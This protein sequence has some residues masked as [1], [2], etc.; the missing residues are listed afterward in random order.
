MAFVSVE[1]ILFLILVCGI[2]FILPFKYRCGWLLLASY[3]FYILSS[4]KGTAFLLFSTLSV[5]GAGLLMG[6]ADRQARECAAAAEVPL[7]RAEKKEIKAESTSK[8]KRIMLLVLLVNLGILVFLKYYTFFADIADGVLSRSPLSFQMPVLRLFLPLGISFYTLQAIG[9]LVDVY[10]GTVK[11]DRNL[12]SFALFMS[13]FPQIVQGPIPRH[14]QLAKQLFTPHAFAYDRAAQGAQLILW[15]FM[16][17]LLIADRVAPLV[18]EIFSNYESYQGILLL[19]GPLGYGLEVYADFS[20]GM[21][22]AR[23]VAQILGIELSDNFRQ[24]YFSRSVDE[25]WRRWHMS[26]G[27]WMK[28]YVFFPI[29]LSKS[30]GKM[31]KAAR[32]RF[33]NEIGKLIPPFAATFLVFILVGV[34]HGSGWKYVAYGVWNGVF[35]S[36]GILLESW[37]AKTLKAC[38]INAESA[39][40]RIFQMIRTTFYITVGRFFSRGL[41]F[42]AA[43]HMIK[44][45][46]ASGAGL[47]AFSDGTVFQ[48]GINAAN[49]AV[50]GIFLVLLLLVDLFHEKGIPIRQTIAKQRL[51]IRWLIYLGALAVLLVFG[52]YGNGIESTVFIYQQF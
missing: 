49:M 32:K 11:P 1:F 46:F 43:L 22:I 27:S 29:S 10:R 34:W 7:T 20:A 12:A 17:K 5:W 44:N 25:F 24:P 36:A 19:L 15:G 47:S 51:P 9:Y 18:T 28:D 26:L 52:M 6:N 41:S 3:I 40:W 33:G 50:L 23:G 31:G 14:N 4:P 48:L 39:G 16:K 13:F 2:Y 35:V 45:C 8:K 30:F 38:K 21:D 37:C 42:S